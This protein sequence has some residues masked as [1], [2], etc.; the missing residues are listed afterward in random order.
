MRGT[1]MYIVVI[2][3]QTGHESLKNNCSYQHTVIKWNNCP[4][5]LAVV[6]FF[7]FYEISLKCLKWSLHFFSLLNFD[8]F[9]S[10]ELICSNDFEFKQQTFYWLLKKADPSNSSQQYWQIFT[11]DTIF[12]KSRPY[13]KRYSRKNKQTNKKNNN[14]KTNKLICPNDFW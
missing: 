11:I 6:V 10:Y 8:G 1:F 2:V 4:I 5:L 12:I 14:K 7:C 9:S 13:L 3:W